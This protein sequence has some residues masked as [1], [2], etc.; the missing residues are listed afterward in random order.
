[1]RRSLD[2]PEIGLKP[3]D[4]KPYLLD[5]LPRVRILRE[6]R[7]DCGGGSAL[8]ALQALCI[9]REPLDQAT[10]VRQLFGPSGQRGL[11]FSHVSL[12]GLQAIALGLQ[13]GIIDME[14]LQTMFARAN[15]IS[16]DLDLPLQPMRLLASFLVPFRLCNLCCVIIG[17]AIYEATQ[18]SATFGKPIQRR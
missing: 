5:G 2:L 1:M 17:L 11:H 9:L 13:A 7:I 18:D 4:L 16:H 12:D 10:E 14:R 3:C 15:R 8:V 6:P